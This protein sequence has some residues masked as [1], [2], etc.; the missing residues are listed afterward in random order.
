[1]FKIEGIFLE[2]KYWRVLPL[3]RNTRSYIDYLTTI[4]LARVDSDLGTTMLKIPFS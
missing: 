2:S 1:M 3:K 4:C